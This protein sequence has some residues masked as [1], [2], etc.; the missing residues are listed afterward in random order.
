[1]KTA[2]FDYQLPIELIAQKP[3]EPRDTSRLLVVDRREEE[4]LH[5]HF[6][7]LPEFLKPGDLLVHNQTRVIRARLF[8]RKPTGGKVEILLLRQRDDGPS[9]GLSAAHARTWE[10]LVG[11]KRVRPGLTLT[12]LNGPHGAPIDARVEVVDRGER[13]VRVLRF[14]R[15]VLP[16]AQEIGVTP[17]PPYIHETLE[18]DQRYQTVYARKPGS[19]A[20]PTAGLHFTPKLL[21][22]LRE[23]GIRSEFVTLHIGLDTFQPVREE[24]LQAHQMHTEHCSL[25]PEVARQVNQTKLKGHRVVAVGTTSVRV[26]ETAALRAV[27]GDASAESCPWG[28]VTAFEGETDLF[29]YPGHAFRAVDALITNFHLP[30]STLLMLVAAFAGKE[31]IDRAYAEAIDRRYRFFSFGDAMLI[32]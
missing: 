21:H 6:H 14:D 5:R 27:G 19:A 31:L 12:L 26:L 4:I 25:R 10:A 22:R 9:P 20:A 15:P 23:M 17:L 30:R 18:D 29:I 13:A 11:G 24:Q 16:L 8:A 2:E 7:D 1:V 3:I 28:T 32:L